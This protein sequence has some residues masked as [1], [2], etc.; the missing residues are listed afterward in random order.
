MT[1]ELRLTELANAIGLDVKT[2]YAQDGDLTALTTTTKTSL[3]AAINE[4]LA[5]ANTRA[6][7]SH[8]HADATTSVAGFMS[9]A[10]KTKLD[11][12]AAGATANAT[13]AQLRDRST[14]TGTQA[15]STVAGLEI[16]LDSKASTAIATTL[17]PGL[18][19]AADKAKLDGVA[20]GATVNSTDAQLRDRSTHTGTQPFTSITG[21]VPVSQGGTGLTVYTAGN[22][23]RAASANALEQRTP[24]QVLA[25]IGAAASG[26]T[27][28]ASQISDST[29]AGRALL[30]AADAPS[31]RATL[32]LGTAATA[33]SSD[34]TPAAHVGTGGGAHSVAT[35]SV[36]GF[37]SAA[38]KTKLD[39]VA[40][41]ATSNLGTVTSVGASGGTTGLTFTG[42]PV[43]TSG[44]L[45]LGGTLAVSAGGTGATDAAGARTALGAT[46]VGS[47][48]FTL[49]N[50]SAVRFLRINADNT[51]S[52]LDDATMRTALG[53][54]SGSGSVTSV[55]VAVPTG[56]SVTGS[57]I[58]N[59]GTITITYG[60]GFQG[61]TTAE[62][63]KL[64]GVA[65]GAT[66]NATDAQLRD[67]S[68]HTGTQA[69]STITGTVPVGQGGTGITTYTAGNYV[70]AATA[71]TLEQRTPAQVRSDIGAAATTH[72]HV[73]TD[74]SDSTVAGRALLTG[75][76]AAAQRTSLGL[77]T[78]ALA[79]S[80][81]FLASSSRGASN[82]VA[83]LDANGKVPSGQLPAIAIVDTFVVASQVAML[84]LSTAEQGDIAVR[85]DLNKS[86]I[87]TQSPSS[88]LANWQELLTPTDAVTT[89]FGR[90]GNVT[91]QSG[92]YSSFYA[93]LAHVGSGGTA[94]AD[95][96]TSVSGFMSAAD[97]TKLNGIATGATANATDAQLRDRSTHTGTQAFSTI[98]G[99]VPVGQGGTGI[100]ALTT[101]NYL[102]AATASSYEQRTPAQV[103]ADI[104]AAAASHTHTA[105]QISDST[106]AGRTL[107]TA[108]DAAA[109]RTALGATTVG[110]NLFTLPNPSAVRFLR[111]NA[112][113]TI[114]ALDDVSFRTAIGAGTGG[115]GGVTSVAAT[116]PTGFE[117]SGSPITSTGT[118][119]IT[120]AAGFQ[121]YTTAESSKL[122][123]IADGAQVNQTTTVFG[124]SGA[125]VAQSGDYSAFYQ[126]LDSEL[127][128][129]AGLVSAAD[130]L[131]YFTGAGTAT[132]ATFT[133]FGRSLV[134]DADAAT[135]RTT[136]GL[137]SAA[138]SSTGDFT[139]AA[140]V[141]SGGAA[142]AAATTTVAGFMSAA[143]KTKLDGV[144]A[145]AT[146]NATDAQLRDRSTHTGTQAFS[147]I[148]GTVP[149]GQGGTGITSLTTGNYL[150]AA[151][152]SSYEQRTPAQVLADI[153]A[154]AAAHT[155]VAADISNSTV[156]GRALLTAADAPAQRTALGLGTAALSATGDFT[157]AS[158]VG[159]GGAAHAAATTSV[160]GF[161]SAADKTKL[162]GVAT[163]ATA[164]ATDAQLRDRATHTGSQAT[165]TITGLD[166]ALADRVRGTVRITVG[167]TAPVS[168]AI[169]D[170]WI[171]TN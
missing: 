94:H 130:S 67:R 88:V 113:N 120:Y 47:N 45:T 23:V 30:T 123:G 139:P 171:D 159:T 29:A 116:V 168:P 6:A 98:T 38:D 40:A 103:L 162:D 57:P 68:T 56:F 31:Q 39:G 62:A 18:L 22:Y 97:K 81:D 140:H 153:G 64:A 77:G 51:I 133:S 84:A 158:H 92:D 89:V 128:A 63:T 8:T 28:T 95:A 105:S 127:T 109:Q 163:G 79:A 93:P 170:I 110:S 14:H 13:D 17:V 16:A 119:A 125:I 111:I 87:L 54:G 3:A 50:P 35:T 143:D 20:A 136:L 106:A 21:T 66:A 75:A 126:P 46:T 26:H 7:A 2:L 147:T 49:P 118:I 100:T 44:T 48:F 15:I 164:N 101:G 59:S 10:D 154:A 117:V 151:T 85:T 96:T 137:G 12:V 124:R 150:R 146:A 41:G 90:A 53:V 74:I 76:D 32:G 107:L 121:G 83:S 135:A 33:A 55:A 36:A 129:L 138:T 156:A 86:F 91:A 134:D 70:R 52:A 142:H 42:G 114:S 58:T 112:D 5:F 102:R 34:F 141:G 148:T 161:M 25:D 115:G 24:A 19:S 99:T 27:H 166:T 60:A 61:Y 131:P 82:G 65:T 1:F 43:T 149:V 132:L 157:P 72:T 4:V 78:A 108:A 69:F 155:H 145:G 104:G 122:A 71:S 11:G 169:G 160:A 144:A 167:T 73:A 152:A 165:S 37:M 80:G 9:A